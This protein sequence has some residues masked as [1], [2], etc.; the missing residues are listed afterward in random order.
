M[1]RWGS[2]T[3]IAVRWP[4]GK[5]RK[6]RPWGSS[7]K[8]REVREGQNEGPDEEKRRR[9]GCPA[10]VGPGCGS[11]CQCAGV[12]GKAKENWT[13]SVGQVFAVLPSSHLF[14]YIH[15]SKHTYKPAPTFKPQP[16]NAYQ[17]TAKVGGPEI[18]SA[19]RN[20]PIF[21]RL[22]GLLLIICEFAIVGPIFLAT[23]ELGMHLLFG[24]KKSVKT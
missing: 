14:I 18:S 5:A 17:L 23:C 20:P 7:R 13:R 24:F 19:N 15:Y 6:R 2:K 9:W 22:V 10:A 11:D 8:G 4:W 21:Y 3:A 1:R 12:Q 16:S